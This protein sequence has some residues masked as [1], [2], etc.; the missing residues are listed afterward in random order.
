MAPLPVGVPTTS[1]WIAN[2]KNSFAA[3]PFHPIQAAIHRIKCRFTPP[4]WTSTFPKANPIDRLPK[5][6]TP[7][8]I[9]RGAPESLPTGSC[10]LTLALWAEGL[11]DTDAPIDPATL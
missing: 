11:A 6:D 2:R 3:A 4:G 7:Y 10:F 9:S 5:R 1:Q 8:R